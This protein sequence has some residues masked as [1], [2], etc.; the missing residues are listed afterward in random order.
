MQKNKSIGLELTKNRLDIFSKDKEHKAFF[1]FLDLK[2]KQKESIGTQVDILI[3][4]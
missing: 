3:P 2:G 1:V 4:K